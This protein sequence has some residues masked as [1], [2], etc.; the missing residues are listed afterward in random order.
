LKVRSPV[1]DKEETISLN[2]LTKAQQETHRYD[3]S[4]YGSRTTC[5]TT[6]IY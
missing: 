6:G 2:G 3:E 1:G 5:A 4:A